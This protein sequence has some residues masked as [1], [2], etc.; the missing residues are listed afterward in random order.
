MGYACL[1]HAARTAASA[2]EPSAGSAGARA[3]ASS[4]A[5]TARASALRSR[6]ARCAARTPHG[7]PGACVRIDGVR[8]GAAVLPGARVAGAGRAN[9][10]PVTRR[11]PRSLRSATP[12]VRSCPRA[13]AMRRPARACLAASWPQSLAVV[14]A[15]WGPLRPLRA[16]PDTRGCEDAAVAGRREGARAGGQPSPAHEGATEIAMPRSLHGSRE[17]AGSQKAE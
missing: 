8:V 10:S 17:R 1:R 12:L 14:D 15:G 7:A 16:L 3:S 13:S 4:A 6:A 11:V 2:S 5:S 9:L